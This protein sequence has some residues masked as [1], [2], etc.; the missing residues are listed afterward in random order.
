M[1]CQNLHG[2]E[3]LSV[4]SPSRR[5]QKFGKCKRFLKQQNQI[6]E[7]IKMSMLLIQNYILQIG[8]LFIGTCLTFIVAVMFLSQ[9]F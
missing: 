2:L 6:L 8:L 9:I 5:N 1:A 4:K 7:V 3:T